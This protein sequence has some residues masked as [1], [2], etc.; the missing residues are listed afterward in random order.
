M[1]T[2]TNDTLSKEIL[3]TLALLDNRLSR[4]E[5]YL[6]IK[7]A[8]I[9]E[10]SET[11]ES[12]TKKT[13]TDEELEFRIGQFWFA[14]LGMLV[15]LIG[16]LITCT[17]PFEGIN[18]IIPSA[19]ALLIGMMLIILSGYLMQRIPHL[20][21]YFLGSGFLIIYLAVLR[22]HFFSPDPVISN[23]IVLTI[24]LYVVAGFIIFAGFKKSS[25][26]IT[27]VGIICLNLS[28]LLSES[29]Y[30]I[31]FTLAFTSLT[32]VYIKRNYNWL[33]LF[34]AII[35]I[36][37]FVHLTWFINNPVVGNELQIVT[38]LPVNLIFILLYQLIFSFSFFADKNFEE[39]LV[40]EAGILINCSVGYG[41]FLLITILSQ[42]EF[43]QLYHLLASIIYLSFA[44]SFFKKKS[45]RISTFF[46]AMTGYGA[47]SVAIIMQFNAP[48]FFI[49]LC[50][51]SLLVVSTAIWFRSKFIIIA[52]FV[53]FLLIFIAFLGISGVT[54]GISLSFGIV[55][56][57]S[58]RL[59]NWK[60]DQL[61]LKTEYM[62]NAY[63]LTAFLIIPY[64]LY[65]MFPS[66]FV[67]LAW[68]L[69]AIIYYF[70]S[71]VLKSVKYRW[72]SVATF[73]LTVVY[74]FIMGITSSET[75]YKILSFLVLGVALVILSIVYAKNKNK[76]SKLNL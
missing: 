11:T 10:V 60:K 28:S 29:S 72:M 64:S 4:I 19:V 53:I 17:L 52:N 57:I 59:L 73:L 42:P 30:T 1:D 22:L 69:V 7:P 23:N 55:A 25:P 26:Y 41:L 49:W 70:L 15:F 37:Y 46:F 3:K 34:N 76:P 20:S 50:W 38:A 35:L 61:E 36:T 48:Y 65:H 45:G 9:N 75:S 71:T 74:V 33:S 39:N 32:G 44:I 56:L 54:S 68:I 8:E 16:C 21:G 12:K 14:K 63:L 24:L 58:A 13:E 67:A 2:S 31:F 62:R 51:Q 5:N 47:L 6:N 40:T 27:A 43:S 66:E 18:Q